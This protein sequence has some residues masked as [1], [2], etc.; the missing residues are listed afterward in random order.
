MLLS[1]SRYWF[2]THRTCWDRNFT[3]TFTEDLPSWLHTAFERSRTGYPHWQTPGVSPAWLQQWQLPLYLRT[4]SLT[5]FYYW[6]NANFDVFGVSVTQGPIQFTQTLLLLLLLLITYLLQLNYHSVAVVLTLVQ[7]KQT[8]I[9]ILFVAQ[10][11]L[12]KSRR[13]TSHV[14]NVRQN[15]LKGPVWQSYYLTNIL[16]SLSTTCKDSLANFAMFTGVVLVDASSRK[17][18]AVDRGSSFLEAFVP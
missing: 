1:C 8:R 2:S 5:T 17:L 14:Q 10:Q 16:D 12:Y 11:S 3:C 4:R 13:N 9:N 15:A 18:I 6:C 7:T